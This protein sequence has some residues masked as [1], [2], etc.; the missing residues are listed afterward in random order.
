MSTTMVK[1][2]A[3]RRKT[4]SQPLRNHPSRRSK[5]KTKIVI[6]R[7]HFMEA[8]RLRILVENQLLDKLVA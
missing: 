3:N 2:E 5:T 1:A 6:R 8:E 7:P 4:M